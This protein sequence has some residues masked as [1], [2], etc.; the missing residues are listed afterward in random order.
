MQHFTSVVSRHYL[1]TPGHYPRRPCAQGE[2]SPSD[3]A[4]WESGWHFLPTNERD[5]PVSDSVRLVASVGPAW[6][7]STASAQ[8]HVGLSTHHSQCG[9]RNLRQE[10]GVGRWLFARAKIP[11][12]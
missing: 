4:P 3:G 1:V 11:R 2:S 10:S 6:E 7:V 9:L 5:S 12:A 8:N